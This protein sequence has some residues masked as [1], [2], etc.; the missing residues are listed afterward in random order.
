RLGDTSE[1][2]LYTNKFKYEDT[3]DTVALDSINSVLNQQGDTVGEAS[4]N[5][6]D[7]A[8]DFYIHDYK[9]PANMPFVPY[10]EDVLAEGMGGTLSNSFTNISLKAIEGVGPQYLGGQDTM[11]E[12][13]LITD[14]LVIVSALN[15]LPMMASAMAK[16]YKRIL[17]AWP[18]K[19]RS[20]L[21]N[22]L[23]V[24]EVL[25]DAIE[26]STVEGYP[27]VYSIAMRLTS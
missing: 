23:G 6:Q 20:A 13:N 24:S 25:I 1:S 15:N 8:I 14:D 10:V 9:N 19:V 18:I 7:E 2:N 5:N 22:M 27:G 4:N 21:T 12:L 11:I 3:Y 16:R 17:P 26:V